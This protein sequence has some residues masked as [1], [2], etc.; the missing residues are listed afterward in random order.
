MKVKHS[1]ILIFFF[2]IFISFSTL[3]QSSN[4]LVVE[5]TGT[6]DQSTVEILKESMQQ[7]RS[8]KSEAII[9]LLDTPGGGLQETFEIA[10]MINESNIPV[11]GY[12]YPSGSYAWS[13]GTFILMST[14]IAAMANFT[15][16]GSCQPVEI[17]A[18]G[19]KYITESK[20]INALVSWIQTRAEMYDRNQ[21]IAGKFI[22]E[23]LDLNATLAE[24]YGV[25]EFVSP[26]ID[27]LLLDINGTLVQT[28]KGNVILDTL[29]A[30]QIVYSPSLGIQFMKFFSNPI[31]TSL[32][33]I[34]GIFALIFG[35]SSP[36]YGAEVFGVIAILLSLI[37]SGFAISLLS[38][39]FIIIGCLLLIIEIF[40]TPGFG[41]IG[42]GGIIL[43]ILG[44]IFLIPSYS[45]T[46]W[47]IY[48]DWIN[49]AMLVLVS[50]AVIIAIFF[51][52]LLYK[53]IQVRKKKAA[54][55]TFVGETAKTIDRISPDK[56]G[57]VRFKGEL[58]L[59]TSDTV[60]EPN[61]KV[62]ILQKDESTLK[63]KLKE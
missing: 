7:A 5:I 35:I 18:E 10:D 21:T 23:N 48:M 59:A 62:I 45:T 50:A 1:L 38:I 29:G 37:G 58:W 13:A 33:L 12:V 15:V 20:I 3:A 57:Y 47:V 8:E 41:I 54:V 19:T 11:V 30:N 49:D 25:V 51:I 27:E 4:V 55:G 39:I 28:S 2:L 60:I 14:H 36:G 61:K 26:S 32:L 16:I 40:A 34:L 6:I 43:L 17:T 42:I 31:L 24:K 22:T 56:S 44:G 9:L 52:F 53:V 46:G 63:V